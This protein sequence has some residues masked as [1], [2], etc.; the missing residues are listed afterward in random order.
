MK[1]KKLPISEDSVVANDWLNGRRSPFANQTLK[2][3]IMGLTLGTTA[4]EIFKS[5]VE[6]TA[7][8]SRAIMEHLKK[9]VLK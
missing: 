8:G 7:F 2:G 5:L 4:P 6:A 9:R 3:A 1:Q